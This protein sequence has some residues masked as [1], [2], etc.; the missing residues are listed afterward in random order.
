MMTKEV[1]LDKYLCTC[2]NISRKEA[3]EYIKK[4]RVQVDGQV[5]KKPEQK[6]SL[7]E[8]NVLFEG[9][10]LG[11]EEFHYL[12]LYK[13]QGVVSATKDNYDQTVLELVKEPFVQKLFPV[14]RLDKDTEGLLLLTDDGDLAHKLLSPRKHVEKTYYAKVTGYIDDEAVQRFAQG[15][16]IGDG[17]VSR[18]AKL[19]IL[20]ATK[21]ESELLITITE[22]K[23][24]QIKRMVMSIGSE[25]LYLKRQSMGPL[26]LDEALGVGNWRAL[27]K[28]EINLL[29][30]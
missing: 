25:V 10:Q 13:P 26:M 24:H 17:E 2:L 9:N 15:I 11:Y 16:P 20:C 21:E 4:G 27:T 5:I 30:E 8:G 12:M 19:Q 28:E 3:K 14:G 22:G 6:V 23:F 1:R 29:K 18:P 7:K